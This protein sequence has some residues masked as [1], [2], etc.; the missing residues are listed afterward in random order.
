MSDMTM[1][2][3]VCL[4]RKQLEKPQWSDEEREMQA[5]RAALASSDIS[6]AR[7]KAIDAQ[8]EEYYSLD[9]EDLVRVF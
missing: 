3:C 8:L 1:A 5:E 6:D 4:L 9:F 2:L 7:K